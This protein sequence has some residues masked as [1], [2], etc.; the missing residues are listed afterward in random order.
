MKVP[1]ELIGAQ[2]W[3]NVLGFGIERSVVKRD[4]ASRGGQN[5]FGVDDR[6][7]LVSLSAAIGS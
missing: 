5:S 1:V 3:V 6:T 7:L 2:K 4:P